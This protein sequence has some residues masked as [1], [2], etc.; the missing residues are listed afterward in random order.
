VTYL[1]TFVCY[2]CHLHGSE[3]GSVDPAHNAPGTPTL[4]RDSARVA[5]AG[6]RMDQPPDHLDQVRRDTVLKAVQE[7]CVHRSWNLLAAPVGSNHV[8]T[9]VGSGGSAG[10]SH[11]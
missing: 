6:Q 8:R 9:V 1:I 3:A 10:A 5:F 11:E 4:E 2:G 7:V